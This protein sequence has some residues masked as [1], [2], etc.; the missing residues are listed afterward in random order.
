MKQQMPDSLVA[1]PS[2]GAAVIWLWSVPVE[3]WAAFAGLL[4]I[5]LQIVHRLWR[6]RNEAHDREHGRPTPPTDRGDL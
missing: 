4:F 2:V 1:V 3:K 5:V 6:W